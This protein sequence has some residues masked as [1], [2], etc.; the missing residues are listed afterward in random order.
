MGVL[1]NSDWSLCSATT[2]PTITFQYHTYFQTYLQ[3]VSVTREELTPRYTQLEVSL[4]SIP[5]S[6]LTIGLDIELIQRLIDG[7]L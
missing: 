2:W 5:V 1:I 4:L 3:L 7:S 6:C